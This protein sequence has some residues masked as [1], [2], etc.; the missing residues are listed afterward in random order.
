VKYYLFENSDKEGSRVVYRSAD[1]PQLVDTT[2]PDTFRVI[3][4]RAGY[5]VQQSIH[6]GLAEVPVGLYLADR[7]GKVL[8]ATE[9]GPEEFKWMTFIIKNPVVMCL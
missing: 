3:Y 6:V 5:G 4:S 9:F 7:L 1:E 8:Q 2:V